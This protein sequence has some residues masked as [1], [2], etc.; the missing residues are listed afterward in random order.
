LVGLL[1]LTARD[2]RLMQ[3]S[4]VIL[5]GLVFES[6]V[7]RPPPLMNRRILRASAGWAD[8]QDF[9]IEPLVI[10]PDPAGQG[11]FHR[12][13]L[14]RSSNLVLACRL[15]QLLIVFVDL[16]EVILHRLQVILGWLPVTDRGLHR[17]IAGR[18]LDLRLRSV[19]NR[20]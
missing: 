8:V 3:R 1:R 5:G 9:T 14:A 7:D 4:Q 15:I 18:S 10:L 12:S 2:I 13:E 16:L 20:H 19:Y 6:V 11:V 17:P